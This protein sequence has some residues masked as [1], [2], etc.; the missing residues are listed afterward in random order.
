MEIRVFKFISCRF[1]ALGACT[2]STCSILDNAVSRTTAALLANTSHLVEV[3]KRILL[4]EIADLAH[5]RTNKPPI[6][7]EALEIARA[8]DAAIIFADRL[9]ILD[10]Y[11]ETER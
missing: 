7:F 3:G 2:W 1:V 5:V 6:F 10:T 9:I 8:L 4:W 11:P